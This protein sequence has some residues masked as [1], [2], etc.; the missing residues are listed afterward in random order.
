MERRWTLSVESAA[1]LSHVRLGFALSRTRLGRATLQ[2]VRD[3]VAVERVTAFG[4][5]AGGLTLSAP[6][7]WSIE[8]G[9]VLELVASYEGEPPVLVRAEIGADEKERAPGSA[10][11]L[12]YDGIATAPAAWAAA[13]RWV[14]P[15]EVPP[16]EADTDLE[17]EAK[18]LFGDRR[19]AAKAFRAAV[20]FFAALDRRSFF[21]PPPDRPFEE[22]MQRVQC[23][24]LE[25]LDVRIHLA[26]LSNGSRGAHFTEL[27]DFDEF[28]CRDDLPRVSE[29][30]TRCSRAHLK[31][32]PRL[33]SWAFE[34]FVTGRLSTP[35]WDEETDKKLRFHGSANSGNFLQFPELAFLCIENDVDVDFW[36]ARVHHLVRAAHAFLLR[37]RPKQ[38]ASGLPADSP[39]SWVERYGYYPGISMNVEVLC[40]LRELHASYVRV[41]AP[42]WLDRLRIAFGFLLKG[43]DSK[44]WGLD[45]ILPGVVGEPPPDSWTRVEESEIGRPGELWL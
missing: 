23:A 40:K 2:H 29:L 35:H 14:P 19:R 17:A 26:T 41:G 8:P 21:V 9:D 15:P 32:D 45:G 1:R 24:L 22:R 42:A 37:P 16:E 6:L 36:T 31:D 33:F 7:D 38:E 39:W 43:L 20:E 10:F 28:G 5:S 3:A 27:K 18:K 13:A 44:H 12:L 25:R 4:R 34:M 11:H 30:F